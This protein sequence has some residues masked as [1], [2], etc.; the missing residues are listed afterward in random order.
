MGKK[1]NQRIEELI[2][3][4]QHK[5][6]V[7]VFLYLKKQR[8]FP[9]CV[10]KHFI[11]NYI[12]IKNVKYVSLRNIITFCNNKSNVLLESSLVKNTQYCNNYYVDG[13]VRYSQTKNFISEAIIISHRYS[14]VYIDSHFSVS[15]G[16]TVARFKPGFMFLQCFIKNI[17]EFYLNLNFVTSINQIKNLKI[18]LFNYATQWLLDSICQKHTIKAI[19]KKISL[20]LRI[21]TLKEAINET[22]NELAEYNSI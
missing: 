3:V 13:E 11:E 17:I 2:N 10:V 7:Y 6:L 18:P 1:T 16:Y 9:K 21:S 22:I 5:I 14:A 12:K 20:R 19:S 4:M 8:N 15:S